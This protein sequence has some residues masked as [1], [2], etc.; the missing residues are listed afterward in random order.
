MDPKPNNGQ[1][2]QPATANPAANPAIS[3]AANLAISPAERAAQIKA[4][5]IGR[6]LTLPFMA[7]GLFIFAGLN[8]LAN[9]TFALLT[10]EAGVSGLTVLSMVAGIVGLAVVLTF[11]TTLSNALAWTLGAIGLAGILSALNR[12]IVEGPLFIPVAIG[13]F[14]LLT[15]AALAARWDTKF[16]WDPNRERR[17]KKAK[18]AQ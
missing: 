6:M 5:R 3:P 1:E 16:F 2:T 8:S 18:P 17:K 9:G 10:P 15:L 7:V 12:P 4:A 13:V 14:I 11:Q